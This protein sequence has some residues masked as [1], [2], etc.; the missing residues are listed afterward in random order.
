MLIAF[1]LFYLPCLLSIYAWEKGSSGE[2]MFPVRDLN[3]NEI[4]I[5]VRGRPRV[6]Y[7]YFEFYR[8]SKCAWPLV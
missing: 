3:E 1:T 5:Q 7:V 8:M 4:H 6:I 2:A